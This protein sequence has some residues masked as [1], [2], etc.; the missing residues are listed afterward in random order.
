MC[1]SSNWTLQMHGNAMKKSLFSSL[2]VK[3][4][5][6]GGGGRGGGGE[7]GVFSRTPCQEG[8]T[9]AEQHHSGRKKTSAFQGGQARGVEGV[10]EV[11][12]TVKSPLL[13]QATASYWSYW[14]PVFL[15]I[16]T[17]IKTFFHPERSTTKQNKV[18][19]S[20]TPRGSVGFTEKRKANA[21]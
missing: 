1:P 5:G 13:R 4:G 20:T 16:V 11:R 2:G 7:E 6:G 14:P 10:R 12:E 17:N 21:I 18:C 3:T 8:R 9:R 15:L 19:I